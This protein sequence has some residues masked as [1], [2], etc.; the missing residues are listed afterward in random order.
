[1]HGWGF[2]FLGL[3]RVA[4][5]ERLPEDRAGAK[6]GRH[7][8]L[9]G[10]SRAGELRG[11]LRFAVLI[12]AL[13]CEATLEGVVRGARTH[14]SQVLVVDDGSRDATS[15]R[16]RE[17]G[18]DVVRHAVNRGKGAA[19]RT[20]MQALLERGATHALSMDADGQHLASDI[21]ALLAAA[22]AQPDGLVLGARQHEPGSLTPI[23]AF[24]NAFANRWVK[25]AC[26]AELEDTQ[27]GLRVY[28]LRET[29]ALGCRAD[30]F[31]FET[32]V[33]IRAVR[34]GW[35]LSSLPVRVC[36]PPAGQRV[37]HFRGFADSARIVFTVIGLILRVR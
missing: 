23:R 36:N 33:I 4:R 14:V 1:L 3:A 29:L 19:L 10:S 17:A 22:A 31:A 28:P 18:A 5:P 35:K 32:E 8:R 12:P 27:T 24:G 30:R 21:P 2:P 13:D 6:A 20:G 37:S 7:E 15:Q 16:A 25:I 34:A 26:G 11:V 9:T